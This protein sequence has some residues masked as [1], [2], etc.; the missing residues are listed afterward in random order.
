MNSI[1]G[2]WL[3]MKGVLRA[4]RQVIN[5]RLE[6]LGLSSLEGD[7]LFHL[8]TGGDQ[9]HQEELAERLDIGKAAVSRAV[10]S[11]E[12]KGYVRRAQAPEDGRAR[13]VTLTD[14]ARAAGAGIVGVYETLYQIACAG[15][16]EEEL[17]R[18]GAVLARVAANLQ[19]LGGQECDWN[20]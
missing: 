10:D 4:S 20:S 6:P 11:L 1:R 19:T 12:D 17:R 8:L 7:L 3:G 5:A 9:P 14:K 15:V 13:C 18:I 2:F 16:D